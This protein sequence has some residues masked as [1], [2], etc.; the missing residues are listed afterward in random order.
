MTDSGGETVL[1]KMAIFLAVAAA[2]GFSDVFAGRNQATA[3]EDPAR[4]HGIG[5]VGIRALDLERCNCL[6]RRAQ[7]GAFEP[8][9]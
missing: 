4:D 1:P 5:G 2:E 3:D 6:I 8:A 9:G 7:F